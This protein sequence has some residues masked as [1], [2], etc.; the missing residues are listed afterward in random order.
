VNIKLILLAIVAAILF[1]GLLTYSM[2]S[3]R[4]A[5]VE[6]CM[7]FAGRSECKI[8]AGA[9]REEA[10]RTAVDNACGLIA[11]GVTETR[12]CLGT[13]PKSIRDLN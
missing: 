2:L 9:T 10:I 4:K 8:A 1:A 5:R 7:D 6:V 12:N 11:A 13:R 3:G